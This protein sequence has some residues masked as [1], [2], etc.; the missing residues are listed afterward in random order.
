MEQVFEL[1]VVISALDHFTGPMRN[2]AREMASA[3]KNI[4]DI[5]SAMKMLGKSSA[6]IDRI[7]SSLQ[8][9]GARNE[10]AKIAKDLK[11]IGMARSEIDQLEQS[12]MRLVEVQQ[13]SNKLTEQM[14]KGKKD[15]LTGMA[16]IAA[17]AG[18]LKALTGL[19]E[20]AGQIQMQDIQLGGIYGYKTDSK[21]I[22]A[23]E[24]Q[25][26]DLSM[27]T[28]FSK[29]DLMGINLE[30]AHAGLSY[31]SLMKTAPEAT[32]LAEVEVGM[33]KS[34]SANQTAYNFARMVD[35]AG[36]SNNVNKMKEFADSMYRVINVTH[37]SS[38]SLGETFKYAMPVTKQL[39]WNE[40]DLLLASAVAAR[41]GMEGSM[42]GTNIKDFAQR[43]N[44]YKFLGT[45]GGQKQL[46]AMAEAGLLDGVKTD[47]KG[48]IIGFQNAALLKD[49]DH[50]QS[51]SEMVKTMSAKHD[52][53][54]KKGGSELQWS[55]LMNHIFGEQGQ[56]FAL[57]TSHQDAAGKVTKQIN[58]QQ[59]L[60]E[61][62]GNIR[63]SFEGQMHVFKSNF[64]TIGTELGKPIMQQL[65]PALAKAN[66]LL[67]KF[68]GYLQK[69]PKAGKIFADVALG[70][71]SFL[72]LGGSLKVV[73]G[74]I[75]FALAGFK[76]FKLT[77]QVGEASK[78]A[79]S[80]KMLSAAVNMFK[81]TKASGEL[82]KF[83]KVVNALKFKNAAGELTRFGKIASGL[84]SGLAKAGS[85]VS[86][87][88]GMIS[89]G[90]G[91]G[92]VSSGRALGKLG[93]EVIRLG[94]TLSKG[95]GKG[96][97]TA[98]SAMG[99]FSQAA[100]RMGGT[101]SR[102]LG[103]GLL[104]VGKAMGTFGMSALRLGGQLTSGLGKGLLTTAKFLGQ[105]GLALARLGIQATIW[106]ARMAASWLI[107][108][109][110][111]GWIIAGVTAVIGAGILA[112]THNFFGFRDKMIALWNYIKSNWV[113]IVLSA[114]GIVGQ[115]V[116]ALMNAWNSNFG[117]I[118]TTTMKVINDIKKFFTDLF[119]GDLNKIPGD[120]LKLGKD[121]VNGLINGIKSMAGAIG[122]TIKNIGSSISNTFKSIMGIHSPSRVFADH[123][124]WIVAGLS[125]GIDQNAKMVTSS[126]Y[127]LAKGI[128]DSFKGKNSLS[129]SLDKTNL[130][131]LKENTLAKVNW[132]ALKFNENAIPTNLIN[133]SRTLTKGATD[134]LNIGKSIKIE[135][136][137]MNDTNHSWNNI[138]KL[139]SGQW[140]GLEKKSNNWTNNS[141][142]WGKDI[143]HGLTDGIKSRYGL[144]L[145]TVKDLG[146]KVSSS[147]KN[148]LGIHSPSTVFMDH[149]KFIV[150]GLSLG[151][152]QNAK[153][154]RQSTVDLGKG[155]SSSFNAN[156][157]V[158]LAG[159]TGTEGAGTLYQDNSQ[160][161]FQ[162]GAI[163]I[164]QQ[165]GQ[166]A[167][168]LA[169][170]IMKELGKKLRNES[171]R[172]GNKPVNA[173]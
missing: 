112:W 130:G 115:A 120:M 167:K 113:Q 23:I 7:S 158:S 33:G 116:V 57:L 101:L 114:T 89:K 30:L 165:P 31:S 140:I 94:G 149:G 16:M 75:K 56:T 139:F 93:Q 110:P 95:I 55:A 169:N 66:A 18:G 45:K 58:G 37:A 88:G 15:I 73:S 161:I 6:D 29:S 118:R 64:A 98:G 156:H 142:Q 150:Q 133:Y 5:K 153:M 69:N 3:Q 160:I 148:V 20:K 168:S 141:L 43:I 81:L 92:V 36:I 171:Y 84:G 53:F 104:T 135:W 71:S 60:H 11:S 62:I 102:S 61:Q 25:A 13:K 129:L 131:A 151:I 146:D 68:I 99:R 85:A 17:G 128:N 124:K 163:V 27:K 83:G 138:G 2:M 42:A 40:N 147:F 39:G 162:S 100:I 26:Q 86:R 143:V 121:I 32:Y 35:D 48:N 173:W 72:M 28:L 41:S 50:I 103:Q 132:S 51:Y 144:L 87:F 122:D 126:T 123:G 74:S 166:N 24:K 90:L 96:L 65:T 152:D 54:I 136:P 134:L 34:A 67:A 9:M 127:N 78:L 77:R 159:N 97:L 59:S 111:V 108:M 38:E 164:Q 4:N 105:F 117:Q 125:Q 119:H 14:S 157:S 137:V 10:F 155:V 172:T 49:K 47:K 80:F 91:K 145:N 44:P 46:E 107:A 12:Y 106:A 79:S 154:A 109:G 82:T 170:E 21:Q 22:Q 8:K 19:A 63:N 76:L 1:G 70:V 52:A